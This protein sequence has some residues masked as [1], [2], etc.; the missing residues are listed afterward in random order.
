VTDDQWSKQLLASPRWRLCETLLWIVF[1]DTGRIR[2]NLP[3]DHEKLGAGSLIAYVRLSLPRWLDVAEEHPTQMLMAA[4]ASG[5]VT[6]LGA[7]WLPLE[8]TFRDTAAIPAHEWDFL[9]F[10]DS[11]EYPAP[12]TFGAGAYYRGSGPFWAG[13]RF[14]RDSLLFTFPSAPA[15]P[16]KPEP[17]LLA[18]V[19]NVKVEDP[20]GPSPIKRR[21]EA[22]ADRRFGQWCAELASKGEKPTR[23]S[24]ENFARSEGMS[25]KWAREKIA[26]LDPSTRHST[27]RP[28]Q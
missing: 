9:S 1:R 11:G 10:Q 21:S 5:S 18:I 2:A 17:E 13:L 16:P 23:Q 8:K 7:E 22:Q 15:E 24:V 4:L 19:S 27:G 12:T 25:R 26:G 20:A 6:A 14:E 3:F 28:K